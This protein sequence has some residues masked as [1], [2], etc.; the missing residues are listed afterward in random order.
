MDERELR[1]VKDAQL[2][3]A[4]VPETMALDTAGGSLEM[5]NHNIWV[6]REWGWAQRIE[7]PRRGAGECIRRPA[8][9]QTQ[10]PVY[11]VIDVHNPSLIGLM[12]PDMVNKG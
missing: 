5:R 4:G 12:I 11:V 7:L 10:Q 8:Q 2:A 1:I 6:A 3:V 9:S